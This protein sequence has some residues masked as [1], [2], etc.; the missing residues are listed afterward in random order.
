MRAKSVL[1]IDNK[2]LSRYALVMCDCCAMNYW[3]GDAR[4]MTKNQLIKRT[5]ALRK[6]RTILFKKGSESI[7]R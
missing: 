1:S 3:E 7:A 2:T 4:R 5:L 6:H